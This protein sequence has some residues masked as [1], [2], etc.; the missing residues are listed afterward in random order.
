MK[1]ILIL[2]GI[3]IGLALSIQA[4]D[5]TES[6][7]SHGVLFMA[8]GRY[9]NLRRCAA[10]P[11]GTKGGPIADV[12]Y[13][14]KYKFNGNHSLAFNLP[15]FRPILFGI[16]FKMLQFE[17]EF[18]YEFSKVVSE[19]LDLITGPGLGVSFHYGPDYQSQLRDLKNSFFAIGPFF[20]WQT[21]IAFKKEG[22]IRSSASIKAFYVPL[23]AKDRSTGTVLGGA[24]LYSLYFK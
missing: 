21:G 2:I 8:G 4:Q 20:S 5:N 3:L 17:P 24:L 19:K 23:F 10:T 9:D 22:K 12:M 7:F 15:L 13:I 6:K 11:A 1:K 18:T 14:T 16:A